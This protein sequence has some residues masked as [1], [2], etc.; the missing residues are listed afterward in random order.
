MILFFTLSFMIFTHLLQNFSFNFHAECV[1]LIPGN[2]N[3]MRV[4]IIGCGYVG[5]TLAHKLKQHGHEVTGTRHSPEGIL[6]LEANDIPAIELDVTDYEEFKKLDDNFDWV[7]FCAAPAHSTISQYTAVYYQGMRNVLDWLKK[8]KVQKFVYTS[9]TGVYGQNDGS[10]VTEDSPV[11]ATSDTS[12]I[13]IATEEMILR[14]VRESSIPAVI[15]RVAG[16]YGPD[17]GYYFKKFISGEA[18][19]YGDGSRYMNMVHVEDVAGAII[20]ALEK[21]VPGEIYNIVD[22]EPV[23]QIEFYKYLSEIL[24][25]PMPPFSAEQQPTGR[26]QATNKRVSNKKLKEKLNYTFKYPTFREGYTE[27]IKEIQGKNTSNNQKK[28]CRQ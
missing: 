25:K 22:D 13:L 11:F 16:I 1:I 5:L 24:G 6:I 9:S 15:L 17:R 27:I 26:P 2:K 23:T 19:I 18:V 21:G 4:L 10:V 12:K 3:F 7:V 28:D 14:E 20:A 8:T